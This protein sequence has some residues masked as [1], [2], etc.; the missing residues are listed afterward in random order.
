MQTLF[1]AA[2]ARELEGVTD[3][4]VHALPGVHFLLDRDLVLGARLEASAD[5]DV[6][7]LGVLAEHHEVDIRG[8]ASFERAQALVEQLHRPVVD[9]EIELEAGAEQDVARVAVVGH[10]RIAER[11]D[12]DR[13]ELP[14]RVVAAGR[15]GH[16]GLQVVIGA[17]RQQL[18]PQRDPEALLDRAQDLDRFGGHLAADAVAGNHG[19]VRNS[20]HSPLRSNSSIV[21]RAAAGS[22]PPVHLVGPTSAVARDRF[23]GSDP[24][25]QHFLRC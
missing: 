19:D 16:A 7:P 6:Q 21:D 12:E 18:E 10:A 15:Q 25:F 22:Q 17:P 5:A 1:E 11:A 8:R 4:T 24:A 2:R 9:V 20:S 23:S 3:D 13:V 14:Q